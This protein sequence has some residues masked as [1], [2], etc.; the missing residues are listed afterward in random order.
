MNK[1]KA[2][3]LS[4]TSSVILLL[5]TSTVLANDLVLKGYG[6][7]RT[8]GGGHGQMSTHQ[9]VNWGK[10]RMLCL[11]NSQCKGVEFSMRPNGVSGCEVHTD[12]FSFVQGPKA[13]STH[14]VTVWLK[15]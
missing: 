12:Q 8:H 5:S 13:N 9:G 10:C 1:I 2:A 3:V 14:A 6:A 7:W 4:S 11:Q 15:N